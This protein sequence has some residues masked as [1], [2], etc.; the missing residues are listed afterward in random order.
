MALLSHGQKKK[1]N[2]MN[3]VAAGVGIAAAAIAI[4]Q[5]L[6]RIELTAVDWTIGNHPELTAFRLK[7]LDLDGKNKMTDISAMNLIVFRITEL[8]PG[9][10]KELEKS[11]LLMT[12]S[13]GWI[14]NYGLDV[15]LIHFK[16]VSKEEWEELWNGFIQLNSPC[17]V[18][19]ESGTYFGLS[20]IA[21][22]AFDS[23]DSLQRSF[24][25]KYYRIDSLETSISNTKYSRQGLSVRDTLS[26]RSY[27]YYGETKTE[28]TTKKRMNL[29]FYQLKNDDYLIKDFD[30]QI[31]LISNE[32]SLGIFYKRI[33]RSIQIARSTV[34]SINEF[35]NGEQ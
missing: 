27:Q 24:Q 16:L 3:A 19:T 17:N 15:D 12:T 11:L 23:S 7:I 31:K 25:G 10:N 33:G 14:N 18:N 2:A 26:H 22:D 13:A 29:P 8:E 1:E 9:T 28:Y 20:E 32:K 30:D 5:L 35:L 21:S 4:H 6:E 34:N